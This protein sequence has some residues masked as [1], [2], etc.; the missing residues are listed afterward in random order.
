MLLEKA[1]VILMTFLVK[2]QILSRDTSDKITQDDCEMQDVHFNHDN[3]V[4]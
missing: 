2:G 1:H 4:A 3:Y